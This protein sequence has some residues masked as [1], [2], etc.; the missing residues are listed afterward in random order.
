MIKQA[1]EL[2]MQDQRMIRV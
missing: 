1:L 2:S